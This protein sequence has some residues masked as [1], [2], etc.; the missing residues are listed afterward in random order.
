MLHSIIHLGE[1]LL[2]GNPPSLGVNKEE[3][4]PS[5]QGLWPAWVPAQGR[6]QMRA[7]RAFVVS[8][9]LCVPE[10]C[11]SCPSALSILHSFLLGKCSSKH[12]LKE[13]NSSYSLGIVG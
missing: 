1:A 6:H 7:L 10:P 2:K 4:V 12:V 8:P 11:A 3:L 13:S 9:L 5:L